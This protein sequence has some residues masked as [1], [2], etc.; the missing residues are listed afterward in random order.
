MKSNPVCII[1]DDEDVRTVMC[2]ALEFEG[3]AT[4]ELKSGISAIEYLKQLSPDK[5]PSLIIV[6]YMMAG[7]NGFEFIQAI[8]TSYPKTIGK[9]PIAIS[10]GSAFNP[11][12][13]P[14][15]VEL[16]TKPVDLNHFLSVVR[17]HYPAGPSN[18]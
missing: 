10:S 4:L 11:N 5:L 8:R 13:V 18:A 17:R 6:D 12:E 16:L 2:Y 15:N 9:I 3:I 1:D 14:K 7:M